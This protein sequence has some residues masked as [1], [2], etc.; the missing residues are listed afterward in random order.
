MNI[1]VLMSVYFKENPEY[2][3]LALTSIWDD[4]ELKPN[5]IILVKDGP[6]T[7]PLEAEITKFKKRA[8]HCFKTICLPQNVGLTKALNVGIQS[9]H[10][11]LIAR[12]DSDD[13]SAISR[14]KVQHDFFCNNPQT[15]VLGGAIQEFS[16]GNPCLSKRFYPETSEKAKKYIVKACPLAH[17][18]VMMRKKIFEEG[19]FY[20]EKYIT[21]Q[22]I[23][24]WFRL[25]SSGHTISNLSDIVLFYRINSDFVKRRSMAKALNEFGIYWKGICTIYG[26][27]WK[28]IYPLL[29]LVFRLSPGFIV[30]K[31]YSGKLRQ[32]LNSQ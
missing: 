11:E 25:L 8:R 16:D 22:D 27:T 20:N 12:M 1:S 21:S 26:L 14:F 6:L 7:E 18:T 5:E 32:G 2:L 4:Q 30:K 15:D 24:L 3:R 29:R 9:C 31:T 23:D 10:G 28:L 19:Y 17:P 13:I